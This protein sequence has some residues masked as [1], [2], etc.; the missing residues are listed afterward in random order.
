VI[1]AL[2]VTGIVLVVAGMGLPSVVSAQTP[3]QGQAVG[4]LL[5]FGAPRA[6]GQAKARPPGSGIAASPKGE[7]KIADVKQKPPSVKDEP[8]LARAGGGAPVSI[9]DRVARTSGRR[10]DSTVL[11]VTSDQKNA[12]KVNRSVELTDR[13]LLKQN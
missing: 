13:E 11:R 12:P 8:V 9:P 6:G 10:P 7:D 4:L 3:S 1:R 5:L 2:A